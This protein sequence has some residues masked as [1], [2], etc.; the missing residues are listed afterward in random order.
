M[1]HI[2]PERQA[3][4]GEHRGE[5][6][7]T[8]VETMI[9]CVILAIA[10][11]ATVP[12]VTIFYQESTAIQRTYS[13]VD[14]VL[15]ASEDLNQYIRDAVEPAPAASGVPTPPFAVATANA[16]TFYAN[17]G[18]ATGP[19]K[20]VAQITTS[21][22][23]STFVVMGTPADPNSCPMTGSSGTACTYLHSPAHYIAKITNLANGATPVFTYT[24]VGGATTTTPSTSCTAGAGNCPLDI[25]DAV[26]VVLQAKNSTGDMAGYQSL[27][28]P[29]APAY[30]PAVG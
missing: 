27:A 3:R 5:E 23:V 15:L 26:A 7:M 14:Q 17:T 24:L 12:V 9:T 18:S 28:Y 19:Q 29:F 10:M 13:A 21:N 22:G 16:A 6:G 20:V 30:N 4:R 25:I 1:T 8:L 11:A 2:G